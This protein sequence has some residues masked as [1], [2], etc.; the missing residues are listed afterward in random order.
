MIKDDRIT[1]DYGSGGK[2]TSSLIEEMI[3]PL[4]KNEALSQLGDGAILPENLVFSTDSFV[5]SPYFFPGGD[6]GKLAVCGTVN[7]VSMSGGEAKYL[8]LGMIIE[9]GFP[10]ED[11]EKILRSAAEAA[12]MAGV[13]IVTGDTKVV[14]RGK[15]DG[16]FLNT[17][18]IGIVRHANLRP[19]NICPGDKILVSGTMGDHGTAVMLA[20]NENLVRAEIKSDC[21]SLKAMALELMKLGDDLKVMRDPTRGG[22]ITTLCEFS[23][24]VDTGICLNEKDIPVAAAVKSASDILGLD[25]LYAA[26]EGKLIAV[27]SADATED[28]LK[29]MKSFDIGKNAAVIG[30]AVKNENELSNGKVII[31]TTFGG[32]RLAG[33]LTG[34][35]L[36]RIC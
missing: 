36:P 15:C 27:V 17:A 8:S 20:R 12:R 9:E 1:L 21:A 31:N 22:L 6:I 23:E 28:A 4:F 26:N 34:A 24:N 2:K 3:V 25:P 10:A 35:Q 13:Q 14:E 30:S 11:L 29:I 18:G 5:I 19:G 16:I 32:R 7:D 33:K